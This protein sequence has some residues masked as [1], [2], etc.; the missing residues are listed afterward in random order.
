MSL[1]PYDNTFVVPYLCIGTNSPEN[2]KAVGYIIG[3]LVIIKNEEHMLGMLDSIA[4]T[5]WWGVQHFIAPYTYIFPYIHILFV[6]L[7]LALAKIKCY[8]NFCPVK[9]FLNEL[10]A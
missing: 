2:S 1:F 6:T 7:S 10:G 9:L 8:L 3:K 4:C 5:S